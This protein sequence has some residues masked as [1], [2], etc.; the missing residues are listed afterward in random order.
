MKKLPVILLVLSI[1]IGMG[2]FCRGESIGEGNKFIEVKI[3]YHKQFLTTY[4]DRLNSGLKNLSK[5]E[6]LLGTGRITERGNTPNDSIESLVNFGY[7]KGNKAYILGIGRFG[8]TRT[9]WEWDDGHD[10]YCKFDTYFGD[11][12]YRH[13]ILGASNPHP[14]GLVAYVGGGIGLYVSRWSFDDDRIGWVGEWNKVQVKYKDEKGQEKTTEIMMA[15]T[16]KNPRIENS[17]IGWHLTSG[18]ECHFNPDFS[19]NIEGGYR[20][21][22]LENGWTFP[23]DWDIELNPRVV[24][25]DD[26]VPEVD[27]YYDHRY[28]YIF[29]TTDRDQGLELDLSGFSLNLGLNWHF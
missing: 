10:G 26:I 6:N 7:Q 8:E 13:Y 16:F 9:D 19:I 24:V 4:E 3:G 5:E 12:T 17:D 23:S 2:E 22:Y 25:Q 1:L 15:N 21:I 28:V 18:F 20:W 27:K 29:D 14:K 11:F